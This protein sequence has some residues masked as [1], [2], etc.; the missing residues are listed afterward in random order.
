MRRFF[1]HSL[2]VALGL[3][4]VHFLW[5]GGVAPRAAAQEKNQPAWPDSF[6]Q[7]DGYAAT[8][9]PP[10]VAKGAKPAA[11]RQKAIYTWTGGR[12][13]VVE[14]TLARDPAF[15]KRYAPAALKK[16][17]RPPKRLQINKKDAWQFDFPRQQGKVDQVV[18]R[19]V[20]L[21]AADKAIILEQKGFGANLQEVAKKFD[22]AKVEKALAR[23]PKK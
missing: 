15:K 14:I 9:D 11:Y 12:Y 16:E 4:G 19:L 1:I 20:V 10:V 3:A 2:L 21:L 7:L 8:Y 5:L 23:P 18:L 13:E 22:F 17:K 6:I